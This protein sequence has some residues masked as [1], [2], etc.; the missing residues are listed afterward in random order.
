MTDRSC[1]GRAR[2]AP[3]RRSQANPPGQPDASPAPGSSKRPTI[4]RLVMHSCVLFC[5]QKMANGL[6]K[7]IFVHQHRKLCEI[8]QHES[9]GCITAAS[10]RRRSAES[11]PPALHTP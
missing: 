4:S 10:R 11:A 5:T 1:C 2:P 8:A 9:S 7:D 6:L 3:S